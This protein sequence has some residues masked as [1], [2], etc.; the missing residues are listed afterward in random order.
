M[1]KGAPSFDKVA[2][3]NAFTSG[4]LDALPE[5]ERRFIM[6]LAMESAGVAGDQPAVLDAQEFVTARTSAGQDGNRKMPHET[7]VVRRNGTAE[8]RTVDLVRS[9]PLAKEQSSAPYRLRADSRA[10]SAFTAQEVE[11]V[12]SSEDDTEVTPPP[13]KRVPK[14]QSSVSRTSSAAGTVPKVSRPR[15]KTILGH[16]DSALMIL[17]REVRRRNWSDPKILKAKL[18]ELHN[19]RNRLVATEYQELAK[20]FNRDNG[21]AKD[22]TFIHPDK[23]AAFVEHVRLARPE[24]FEDRMPDE[25]DDKS[26]LEEDVRAAEEDGG[27]AE[28]DAGAQ[29]ISTIPMS[30]S[31]SSP[32]LPRPLPPTVNVSR[33]VTSASGKTFPV[34]GYVAPGWEP[35]L[36]AFEEN[37][38]RD[39]ELGAGC[40]VYH[41]EDVV[42]DL[43][44]GWIDK[45]MTKEY[46]FGTINVVFSSSKMVAAFVAL[47]CISQ[48]HFDF[49]DRIAK[50]WPEFGVGN[51][52]KVTVKEMLEHSGGVAW[53]DPPYRPPVEYTLTENLDKLAAL[54]AQQPH[55]NGGKTTRAYHAITRDWCVNEIIRRTRG[56]SI[57][58]L[59][60]PL[61]RELGMR[62][63]C[64]LPREADAFVSPMASHPVRDAF[65]AAAPDVDHPSYKAM[66]GSRPLDGDPNAAEPFEWR[67][68]RG[69]SPSGS[70]LTN[71]HALATVA[72]V[73]ACGGKFRGK[74]YLK[75]EV[76][77][78]AHVVEEENKDQKDLVLNLRFKWTHGGF[79][80]S[81]EGTTWPQ[82]IIS[83]DDPA[84]PKLARFEKLPKDKE[85]RWTGWF[86]AG[87]S[88]IQWNREHRVASGY[89][90]NVMFPGVNGDERGKRICEAVVEAVRAVEG[91]QKL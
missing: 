66:D 29:R 44:G 26:I 1:S 43:V 46:D 75:K 82:I 56:L 23:Q 15:P 79:V 74:E 87:G 7:A 9:V 20:E 58:E 11:S 55:N 70:M 86:G 65:N 60:L 69:Q 2:F 85:F 18:E 14:K 16:E 41:G 10:L 30:S 48:G 12:E 67:M 8:G 72:A 77:E 22:L 57:G 49:D 21:S 6:G 32:V 59:L 63:Y 40:C 81:N 45:A 25:A 33:S 4:K 28:E 37:F 39:L 38:R 53:V 80:E 84:R 68:W 64:G 76:W 36:G 52:D 62:C 13:K 42:V 19:N 83:Y 35:V 90:M 5:E 89:A 24:L 71:A 61:G 34:K 50:I 91:K 17:K 3:L 54:I 31:A 51:K 78:R 27:A 73:M 47:L 88:H